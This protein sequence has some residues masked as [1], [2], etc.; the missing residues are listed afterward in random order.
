MITATRLPHVPGATGIFPTGP[1]VAMF[2]ALVLVAEL[3]EI[4]VVYASS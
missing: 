2:N 3:L 1:K 4:T